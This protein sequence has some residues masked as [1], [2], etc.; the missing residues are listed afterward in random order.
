MPFM[1][2]KDLIKE[3]KTLIPILARGTPAQRKKEAQKQMK[4][5]KKYVLSK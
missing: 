3:H 2:L 4:E 1:S 5:L